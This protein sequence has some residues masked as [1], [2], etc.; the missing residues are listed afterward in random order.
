MNLSAEQESS[1]PSVMAAI[2]LE[3][4]INIRQEQP[5]GVIYFY[6]TS[7]ISSKEKLIACLSRDGKWGLTA[8]IFY[9]LT[10]GSVA[11]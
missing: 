9:L 1:L 10:F 11:K 7:P 5:E 6:G 4:W 8:S 2:K 3:G